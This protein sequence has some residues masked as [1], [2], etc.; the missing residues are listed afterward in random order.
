VEGILTL[1]SYLIRVT[2]I[3]FD[4]IN[5]VDVIAVIL[6]I[7]MGYIGFRLGLGV[8]LVKL[9]GTVGGFFLSF[10]V[11]QA[12]G[13]FLASKTFLSTEWAAALSMSV[14]T[15]AGYF[16]LTRLLRLLEH[17]AKLTFDKKIDRLGG[18]LI[19]MARGLLTAS[20][21][22]TILL[23]LPSPYLQAAIQEKSVSGKTVS[24][25]APAVYDTLNQLSRRFRA[26]S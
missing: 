4:R 5:W 20:V 1:S 14:L 8:E 16:V 24:R 3:P 17:L 21:V 18:L 25:M 13:D 19:G 11:Y 10:R 26:E 15:V 2:N 6:L 22:L 7:R 23:Q 12:V 9:A